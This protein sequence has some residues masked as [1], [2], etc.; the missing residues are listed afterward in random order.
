MDRIEIS[1]AED[2]CPKWGLWEGIRELV[3]NYMDATDTGFPG[4]LKHENDTLTL[5]N[6]KAEITRAQMALF[7]ATT[8]AGDTSQRGQFG[9]GFKIGL[10]ALL[11]DGCGI[12]I[13]TP[14]GCYNPRIVNSSAYQARVL[15]FEQIDNEQ[16]DGVTVRVT[17]ISAVEW[18]QLQDRFLWDSPRDAILV[19]QPGEVFAR[20]IW[21]G[22]FED[23]QYGYNFA[24]INTDR[25][26]KLIASWDLKW[27]TSTLIAHA[28][29]DGRIHADNVLNLLLRGTPDVARLHNFITPPGRGKIAATFKERYGINAVAVD[30]AEELRAAEHHGLRAVVAPPAA[31]AVLKECS[32]EAYRHAELVDSISLNDLDDNEQANFSWALGLVRNVVDD[33]S[34]TVR[35]VS[36]MHEDILGRREDKTIFIA[37]RALADRSTTLMTLVEEFAHIAG[38]DGSFSHKHAIHNIYTSIICEE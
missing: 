17:G 26:R 7:G 16:H 4:H 27:A 19:D 6:A 33:P 14:H 10:L 25:D 3:Q 32:K 20:D 11:R 18:G 15:A 12:N 1:L 28:V 13:W 23:Y 30:T 38:E 36:F 9:E 5:Y 37:R 8:K 22:H 35:V 31:V 24:N 2:Y 21:V 34:A 29:A